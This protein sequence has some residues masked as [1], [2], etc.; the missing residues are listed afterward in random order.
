[1]DD[2]TAIKSRHGEILDEVER[3]FDPR[4]SSFR[5]LDIEIGPDIPHTWISESPRGVVIKLGAAAK[6]NLNEA[7]AQLAHETIHLL[8]PCRKTDVSVLEEGLATSFQLEYG[9]RLIPGYSC[10]GDPR[11]A[12]YED[13]CSQVEALLQIVP[14]AILR[15]RRLGFGLSAVSEADV[16]ALNPRI[17]VEHAKLLVRKFWTEGA[18]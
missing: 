18:A 1:M 11:W 3:R 8:N 9:R 4:D 2:V 13:A 14:D 12:K 16:L 5:I 7:L 17:N 10:S 15:L 6:G